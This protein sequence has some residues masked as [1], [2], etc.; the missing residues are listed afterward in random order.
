MVI[1]LQRQ[2]LALDVLEVA[3]VIKPHGLGG[4]VGVLMHWEGSDALSRANSVRLELADGSRIDREVER[5]RQS[6][7]GYLVKFVGVNGRDAAE[8]LR[9]A[10]VFVDR[11]ILPEVGPGEAFLSDLIGREVVGPDATLIGKV[12]NIVS[13]PSVDCIVIELVDGA[14]V[15]QPL[16]DDWVEPLDSTPGR[17][18][19]RGLDGIFG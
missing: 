9:G 14:R 11:S 13:Y 5:V 7:R 8:A 6:G 2:H 17:V 19:L 15:E 12:V 3:R 4:E 18:I 16:V 10:L 1:S